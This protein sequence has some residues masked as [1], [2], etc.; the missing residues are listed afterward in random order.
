MK[1]NKKIIAA[2][3][4]T[5]A[6]AGGITVAAV[7][8]TCGGDTPAENPT[9]TSIVTALNDLRGYTGGEPA[10]VLQG[11][12][13]AGIIAQLDSNGTDIV[14]SI[15]AL[16]YPA[17]TATNVRMGTTSGTYIATVN[18]VTGTAVNSDTPVSTF[19]ISGNLLV[20]FLV[21]NDAVT[22]T[23]FSGLTANTVNEETVRS[24]VA[25]L[26]NGYIST[27]RTGTNAVSANAISI[28]TALESF[29]STAAGNEGEIVEIND[30]SN[31]T[32][33]V[34]TTAGGA[35]E[36][37]IG[38]DGPD[39]NNAFTAV[40]AQ[41]GNTQT[42]TPHVWYNAGRNAVTI[43]GITVGTNGEM[44]T[45]S[46]VVSN[47]GGDPEATLALDSLFVLRTTLATPISASTT[48]IT[49][50]IAIAAAGTGATYNSSTIPSL[51]IMGPIVPGIVQV[52]RGG[53][54]ILI[55]AG[56]PNLTVNATPMGMSSTD[57][58]SADLITITITFMNDVI[59]TV[60]VN[61]TFV[62]Q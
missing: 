26:T 1:K 2:V 59:D 3:L 32:V 20:T 5:G 50:A 54:Q 4:G 42:D 9:V 48:A 33:D 10:N 29:V 56:A 44:N 30:F 11:L 24:A 16:N 28:L 36:L 38:T 62:E 19:N 51:G 27:N 6:L 22:P 21:E 37:R 60:D 7:A 8:Q 43:A 25:E 31:A 57:Y 40:F 17:I 39:D 45:T 35:V 49:N 46:A 12:L 13:V 15:T 58:D 55:S 34:I 23:I 41:T 53:T 14:T 18:T 47:F 61:G 52:N